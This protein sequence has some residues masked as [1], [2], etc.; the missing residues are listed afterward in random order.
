MIVSPRQFQNARSVL[1]S[2]I[3]LVELV[4]DD[5][6]ARDTGATFVF[7][8]MQRL[9]ALD[10]RFN[11]WGG[12]Y[13]DYAQDQRV[14]AL[15]AAQ[16]QSPVFDVPIVLVGGAICSDGCGTIITTKSCVFDDK[17]NPNLTLGQVETIFQDYLGA[18]TILWIDEGVPFDET[19]GHI[20]NLLAFTKPGEIVLSWCNDQNDPHREVS[21]Q[22]E[23]AL[24]SAGD[25]RGRPIAVRRLP[26]PGPL[27]LASH[28]AQGLAQ[29]HSGGYARKAGDRL[30]ASYAN[31][32]VANDRVIMPLLDPRTDAEAQAVL[33]NCFPGRQVIAIP[34]RE[35]LLGG[36]NIHCITQQV[37]A[38]N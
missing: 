5:A 2:D 8:A 21:L 19:G 9:A 14:A 27:F 38:P 32:Y 4:T 22:A 15:M 25:A 13:R 28:E 31:F 37:P 29:A 23:D 3:R 7:D 20:D 24:R 1:G 12:L 16:D 34:S 33:A 35:I 36:G 30:A 6:W 10:W 26:M 17:R 11:A 18:R